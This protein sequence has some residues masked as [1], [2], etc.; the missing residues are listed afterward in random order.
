LTYSIVAADT[1]SREVGGAGTSCLTGDDVF[2]I[3]RG[4]PGRGVVHAQ[5]YYSLS[6]RDRAAEL[7]DEGDTPTAVLDA[8]T[9][10]SFDPNVA[11]RQYGVIDVRGASAAFTGT[12]TMPFAG[13][14]QGA[15]AQFAYSVQGNILTSAKVLEQAASAFQQSGC[16][17]AEH[18]MVALEAGAHGGQGDSRCTGMGIPSDS[19][20]LQ[21]ESPGL[22]EGDYLSL[23]VESSGQENPLPLLRAKLDEWRVQHPCPVKAPASSTTTHDG[24]GCRVAHSETHD[25]TGLLVGGLLIVACRRKW[26]AR[27]L[28]PIQTAR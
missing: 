25:A 8:V 7:L 14:R 18:L 10:P 4:V 21:V 1:Q 13:D 19:A 26:A 23:H 15:V 17:L 3:Y 16:D 6:S 24:C 20:F 11:I 28:G 27:K 22:A 9:L 5:A 2:V 12:G